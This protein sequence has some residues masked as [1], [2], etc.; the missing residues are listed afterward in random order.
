MVSGER[1]IT[2]STPAVT[3]PP[4]TVE[5]DPEYVYLQAVLERG[6][7]MRARAAALKGHSVETPVDPLV[8][9]LLELELP[10]DE[11]RL[12]PLRHRWNRKLLF[13]LTQEMLAEQ[14]LGLDPTS[15]ST[16][17]GAALV[18]RLWRRA[19]S[20]PAADCRVVEDILALVAA[21]VEAAARARR[22]V[23]RRLVAE[24]GEDVAEEVAERV[25]DALLD[26][27][28]AAVAGGE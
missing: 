6:G 17:S 14:L 9:H 20:F 4:A 16:S 19:R 8:F 21:D 28:I 15:P 7:F 1:K 22:V 27:E 18:A 24:E 23:E 2:S 3:A 12:G 26:A 11:A 13:Q 5:E 25:L 10:A